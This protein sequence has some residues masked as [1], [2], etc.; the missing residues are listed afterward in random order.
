MIRTIITYTAN[1]YYRECTSVSQV[2]V[3]FL[4]SFCSVYQTTVF[5]EKEISKSVLCQN[6]LAPHSQ[7]F[8][9][10][11]E[12]RRPAIVSLFLNILYHTN[13]RMFWLSLCYIGNEISFQGTNEIFLILY[14]IFIFAYIIYIYMGIIEELLHQLPKSIMS[15]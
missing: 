7:Y 10:G 1:L 5:S 3:V 2:S 11:L 8:V 15:I 9:S 13:I 4:A 14:L 12:R 6:F